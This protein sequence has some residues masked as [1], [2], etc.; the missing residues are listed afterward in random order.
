[1]CI[2]PNGSRRILEAC[3]KRDFDTADLYRER[4]QSLEDLR[5]GH[6]PI[7]VLHDAVG[8]AGIAQ[9]GPILPMLSNTTPDLRDSISVAALRL[10]SWEMDM[11]H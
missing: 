6:G 3:K 8:L 4:F 11:F 5:N 9:M 1:M 10:R 2:A 7:S